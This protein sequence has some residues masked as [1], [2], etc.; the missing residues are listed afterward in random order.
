M[1]KGGLVA[2]FANGTAAV[3]SSA[4]TNS[5]S[6]IYDTDATN[7]PTGDTLADITLINTGSVTI[8]V[9]SFTGVTAI[10]GLRVPAGAQ[11]TINGFGA[12]Q[13]STNGDLYAITA[14]GTSSVLVA[15]ATVDAN[16]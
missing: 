6:L 14:S 7:I 11:V 4:V 10:T 2:I 5:S 16:V 8:F 9:G 3:Q 1:K 15:P 12:K 13:S